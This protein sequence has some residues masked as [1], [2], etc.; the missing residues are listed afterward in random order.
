MALINMENLVS[1]SPLVY[2]LVG[3]ILVLGFACQA[4]GF[5]F[6]LTTINA[7][8]PRYRF[9]SILGA[10][11]MVSAFLLL[12]HQWLAWEEFLVYR[13]GMFHP[14]NGIF[15]NG[16]RYL[17]WA[18]DVPM[19]LLQLVIVLGLISQDS[20]RRGAQFVIYGLLMIFTGYIGQFY[21]TTNNFQLWLWFIISSVFYILILVLAWKIIGE[22]LPKLP[23]K[24]RSKMQL[25]RWWFI[26]VWTLYPIAYILPYFSISEY[27]VAW[28]QGLFTLADVL[29]KVIYGAIITFV[30]IDRSIEE[31]YKPSFAWLGR[32]NEIRK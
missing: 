1:Y 31:G 25:V 14:E 4:A 30:A 23:A 17:N 5:I 28:R 13:D 9:V 2:Q 7:S 11:V 16:F 18:I 22:A 26:I 12:F 20:V 6:F 10:I 8:A 19:L 27:S 21:E 32:E 15:S 29:S 24:A 3:Q